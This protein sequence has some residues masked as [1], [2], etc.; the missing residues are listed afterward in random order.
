[1][2]ELK[3]LHPMPLFK[4]PMLIFFV[5]VAIY[6]IVNP[7]LFAILI[8]TMAYYYYNYKETIGDVKKI[9][10]NH[11]NWCKTLPFRGS[12]ILSKYPHLI[13]PLYKIFLTAKKD[14]DTYDAI[15]LLMRFCKIHKFFTKDVSQANDFNMRDMISC[16]RLALDHLI[17]LTW[18][19]RNQEDIDNFMINI[20]AIDKYTSALVSGIIYNVP[21]FTADQFDL[22]TVYEQSVDEP[23]WR[24][25]RIYA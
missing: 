20:K 2:E 1:M 4:Y 9:H 5:S 16:R 24:N 17:S 7:Y 3:E 11:M 14:D 18:K 13:D 23:N 22:N 21:Y 15:F 19:Y 10:D 6:K 8:V 12:Q 25:W